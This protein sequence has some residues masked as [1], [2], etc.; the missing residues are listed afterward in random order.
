MKIITKA[1][2]LMLTQHISRWELRRNAHLRDGSHIEARMIDN[3]MFGAQIA[4][5]LLGFK[6]LARMAKAAQDSAAAIETEAAK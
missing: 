4:L 2:E 3:W 1:D 5:T 6:D